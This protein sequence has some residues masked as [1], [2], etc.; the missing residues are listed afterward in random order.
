[1]NDTYS[2][3]VIHSR[4]DLRL[5]VK[6]PNCITDPTIIVPLR[7]GNKPIIKTGIGNVSGAIVYGTLNAGAV[8]ASQHAAMPPI[9]MN[10]GGSTTDGEVVV[11]SSTPPV[12]WSNPVV[13]SSVA[14]ADS[15]VLVGGYVN[16]DTSP[17]SMTEA[18]SYNGLLAEMER[19]LNDL[20]IVTS[21]SNDPDW[22]H[23]LHSLTP[24]QFG[25]LISKVG[26]LILS[27][28]ISLFDDKFE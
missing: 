15:N 23:L 2:G 1:M 8:S 5:V 3:G 7:I 14:T 6:T 22:D 19:S 4:H 21:H 13:Y 12:G 18:V 17:Y 20:D 24:L 26:E 25:E 10:M 16:S 11:V 28:F 27:C 9:P